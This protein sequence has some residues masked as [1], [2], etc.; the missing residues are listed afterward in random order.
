MIRIRVNKIKYIG[1]KYLWNG[2]NKFIIII[3][4]LLE[5]DIEMKIIKC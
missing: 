3:F 4:K 2:K 5:K 1:S